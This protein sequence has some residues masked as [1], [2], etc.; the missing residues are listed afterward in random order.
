MG[1]TRHRNILRTSFTLHSHPL[2]GE[3][4]VGDT[5]SIFVSGHGTSLCPKAGAGIACFSALKKQRK[6]DLQIARNNLTKWLFAR[7][8]I[9]SLGDLLH[10][11]RVSKIIAFW[12]ILLRSKQR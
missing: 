4:A 10:E 6:A 3:V 5:N 2:E 8:D 1:S 7:T 9:N 11:Q 12:Q